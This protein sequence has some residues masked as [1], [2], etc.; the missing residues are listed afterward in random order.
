[1]SVF[2]PKLRSVIPN[3]DKYTL[4]PYRVYNGNLYVYEFN[5]KYYF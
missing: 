5:V 4:Y 3:W 1:M 2:A